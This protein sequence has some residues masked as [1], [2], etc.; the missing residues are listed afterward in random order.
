MS[1]PFTGEIRMFGFSYAP[2]DWAFCDGAQ[3][4][5]QQNTALYS[6]IGQTYGGSGNTTFNLPKLTGLVPV[7]TG[8]GSGLS[9]WALAQNQGTPSVALTAGQMAVHSHPVSVLSQVLNTAPGYTGTPSAT[10]QPATDSTVLLPFIATATAQTMG[11]ATLGAA[12]A[13][14][15]HENRQPYLPLNFCI[16]LTGV[17]PVRPS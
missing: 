13:G 9:P 1:S 17:Y 15:P 14:A 8:Q 10:T 5:V 4:T 3:L 12:G 7:G 2:I 16:C 11:A 6:I